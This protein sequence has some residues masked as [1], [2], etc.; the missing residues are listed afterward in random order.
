LTR[1]IPAGIVLCLLI[2]ARVGA[3]GD[4]D[5]GHGFWPIDR[6]FE[7]G[8]DCPEEI[9]G[10]P[11][12]VITVPCHAT[13]SHEGDESGAQSWSIGFRAHNAEI[14]NITTEGTAAT[15]FSQGGFERS[16]LTRGFWNEGAFSC[17][18]LSLED[19]T[20]TLPPGS[21]QKIARFDL[22]VTIPDSCRH[23]VLHHV[24]GL[25]TEAKGDIRNTVTQDGDTRPVRRDLHLIR[26]FNRDHPCAP[27]EEPPP[28]PPP[29]PGS[30]IA[31][32]SWNLLLPL[33][34]T[35]GCSAGGPENMLRNWV[36]PH[37]LAR[38]TPM[39]GET[40]TIDYERTAASS[41][42]EAGNLYEAIARTREAL[43]VS[44]EW[45]AAETEGVFAPPGSCAPP[46]ALD[47]EVVDLRAVVGRLNVL[48]QDL[49][50]A[51]VAS[52]NVLAVAQTY[53]QNTTEEPYCAIVCLTSD[54]SAQVWV[55][56]KVVVSSSRCG[57]RA[58][59]CSD[60]GRAVLDPGVN[61]ITV[62][63]WAGEGQWT[64][65]VAL[66]DPETGT[67]LSNANQE[68][69]LF[70]GTDPAGA[71]KR[72]PS[73]VVT[74]KVESPDECPVPNPALV[75]LLGN[76]AGSGD[77]VI[78]ETYGHGGIIGPI[79]DVSDGG[80]VTEVD[81]APVIQ[82]TVPVSVL[83]AG[84]VS[85]RIDLPPGMMAIPSG[86]VNGCDRIAGAVEVKGSWPR[87]GPVGVFDDSHAI[88]TATTLAAGLGSFSL[89][90]GPA[91]DVYTIQGSGED[92][93]DAGDSFHFAYRRLAGD[94]SV[95][96]RITNR[97][98]PPEGG[99][100][101]RYGLMARRDCSPTSKY[102]LVHANLEADPGPDADH[103]RG[104]GVFHQFREAHRS[105]APNA[106]T[107][108][109]FPDPDGDGPGLVN[110]PDF[111]RLVRRG[112]IITGYA[113]FDGRDWKLVGSDAW[114]GLRSGESLLVGFFASKG[115]SP[116]A[117]LVSFGDFVIEKPPAAELFENELATP[118]LALLDEDFDAVP[119]GELPSF[120]VANC[121]GDCDGFSPRVM[122]GRLRLTEEGVQSTASSV[123]LDDPV[124][125]SSGAI[126]VEFTVYASHSGMATQPPSGDPNPGHGIT[127]V[128]LPGNDL[129]R[130]GLAE[131]GLGYEGITRAFAGAGPSLAVEIDTWS[132]TY[133]NE[134]TGS[135]SNDG[136]WHL[137]INTGGAMHSVS[138]N[139][140]SLPDVFGPNGVRLRVV[141]FSDGKVSVFLRP[142]VG[143]GGGA[144]EDP[145]TLIAEAEVEPLGSGGDATGAVG[146]TG[147]T[148]DSTQT[149][150]VD[151]VIVEVTDCTDSAEAAVIATTPMTVRSGT[152]I[153]LDASGSTPGG[154]D[155]TESLSFSWSV[156]GDA[157]IEGS[158][159][160][161]TVTLRISS[162]VGDGEAI[163]RVSVDDGSCTSPASA[164]AERRIIVTDRESTWAT[165]D[166]NNDGNLD[167][168]DPVFH[169]N[170][171][172]GGGAAPGC[173][174]TM[175]FNGDLA[176][177]IS[178]AVSALNYLFLSGTPPA[179]GDGCRFYEHCGLSGRC[180]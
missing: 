117:G 170:F 53:V 83:N 152:M 31:A 169:L 167:I 10:A 99:R 162:P 52:T 2:A 55:N 120:L 36:A 78:V 57:E 54:D 103:E 159:S 147:S 110:Q 136:A 146:F 76:G 114:H 166:G 27:D 42:F 105:A 124:P 30:S 129:H 158:S 168:S 104:D 74:R 56:D 73:L 63:S 174:Q 148:G 48:A 126:S 177:D 17:V 134:G 161:P 62:I 40:W 81:G 155:D 164:S 26:L 18:V 23:A 34:N 7:L 92:I 13:L 145:G 128:I 163:G 179:M 50:I 171:L 144:G 137:G 157:E 100:S 176:V 142:A 8:F 160:G 20:V 4:G 60:L 113:S 123:F 19:P 130:V 47:C 59:E 138:V 96:A 115:P 150:E 9:G 97:V 70:L 49:G 151:D 119:D 90:Q 175:D 133:F 45:L 24:N 125:V 1:K 173:N 44:L 38:E 37:D 91:G 69:I 39:A 156:S 66:K 154:G 28:P 77:A 94:F 140:Q 135:P 14:L 109:S 3:D 58:E 98:F 12:E 108:F 68:R 112:S 61:K 101:A 71:P 33:T 32:G 75:T 106:S 87:S 139:S 180:P 121:A 141:Y 118:A 51:R 132:S 165:Y 21:T 72:A 95:T 172:F 111:F 43:W 149:S 86:T 82:W 64:F 88:G 178:D 29:D 131:G 35:D 143:E 122:G 89:E 11:G 127:M 22:E 80:T 46:D 102:S 84:G 5:D 41:G 67:K 25:R 15:E 65:E 153:Q 116:E 79:S 93:G 16:G 6:S 85:Y 107:G